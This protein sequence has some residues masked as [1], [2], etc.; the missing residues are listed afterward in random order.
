MARG[1]LALSTEAPVLWA[2]PS[3]DVLFETAAEAYGE[4]LI[5]VILTG[6]NEDGA[7]GLSRVKEL[8]GYTIVED[9]EFAVMKDPGS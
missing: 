3:I 8:G 1:Q 5:A 4:S 9:P 6:A 2:R 7:Q